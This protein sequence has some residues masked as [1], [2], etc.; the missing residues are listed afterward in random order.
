MVD[1]RRLP[2]EYYREIFETASESIFI[3]DFKAN[4]I[5]SN[6]AWQ[7]ITGYSRDELYNIKVTQLL[8]EKGLALAREV[9]QKLLSG[10]SI[11][12]PY[13]QRIIKKDRT[14]AILEL[15]TSL[16]SIGGEPVGF[17]H[18]AR[19]VTEERKMRD[20]LR[21]YLQAILRTQE[22]ERKRIA[23]EL[24]DETIQSLL[25]LAHRLDSVISDSSRKLS[26]SI[27]EELEQLHR[28]AV[29]I[30]EGL[31]RYTRNLRPRILDDM[32]LV[33]ALEYI[34]DETIDS[35]GID[36]SVQVVGAMPALSSE[37][38]LVIFRIAQEALNNVRKH[39]E[40]SRVVV[41]LEFEER[42]MRMTISD[43]G[44]GFEIPKQLDDFPSSGRLGLVGM[45]ERARLLGGNFQVQSGL[46]KGTE[47][48]VELPLESG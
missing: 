30:C 29:E 41:R 43:D 23:R 45:Y 26:K 3:H 13:E 20:S 5:A 15:F 24:H 21:F 47:V 9:R 12:M 33:A 38:Q 44:Q 16:V 4:V 17:L 48:V 6:K 34:A 25:L 27:K 39:T 8:D 36:V 18:L 28:L 37:A 11:D 31:W 19:D 14:Q 22:D 2:D 46:G 7:K 40:A 32:G 35:E 42:K 10:E 1:P